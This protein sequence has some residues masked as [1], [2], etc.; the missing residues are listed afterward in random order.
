MPLPVTKGQ[1]N[2]LGDR[3]IASEAIDP[4]DLEELALALAAYQEVLDRVK[5]QLRILGFSSTGRV[6]TTGTL[7]DKLRRIHGMQLSRVQDLAGARI[8]VRDRELQDDAAEKIRSLYEAEGCAYRIV[9]RRKNPTF[10][11]RAVHVVVYVDGLPLE[12]QVRTELQDA[13]AQIVER[14]ADR[15]GRG[16]RYGENPE[17]PEARVRS[18]SLSTSRRGAVDLLAQLSDAIAHVEELRPAVTAAEKE[19]GQL[20][21]MIKKLESDVRQKPDTLLNKITFDMMPLRDHLA[22]ALAD[23][24]EPVD[25]TLLTAGANTTFAQLLSLFELHERYRQRQLSALAKT[26]QDNERRVR[27][28]L[29]LVADAT[30]EGE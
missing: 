6:K 24:D 22:T 11:Y 15:W 18:R 1:L 13:W 20:V 7:V 25:Q 4:A 23:G 26:S 12:I 27:D 2:R 8:V 21:P 5:A 29:K 30:D 17:N 19:F 3:L 28:I 10:G 16:I 9:D 14:L